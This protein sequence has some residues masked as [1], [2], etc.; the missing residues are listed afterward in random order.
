MYFLGPSPLL[1]SFDNH[2]QS[3]KVNGDDYSRK[4]CQEIL[5][6]LQI[7]ILKRHSSMKQLVKKW[8]KNF[9]LNH[10]RSPAAKDFEDDNNAFENY[11]LMMRCKKLLQLW[12]I[13]F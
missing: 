3:F 8:E 1:Q 4:R 10:N 11:K 6:Q 7:Q 9:Y 2:H 12:K 5:P 13:K